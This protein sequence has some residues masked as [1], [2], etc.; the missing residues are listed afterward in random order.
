M[1][2]STYINPSLA[3]SSKDLGWQTEISDRFL[4][5]T[6]G[7][8]KGKGKKTPKK[9]K[10]ILSFKSRYSSAL[11]QALPIQAKRRLYRGTCWLRETHERTTVFAFGR[12]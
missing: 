4:G 2:V 1:H 6:M 12:S 5:R 7:W 3:L 11:P 8:R 9:E 10:A